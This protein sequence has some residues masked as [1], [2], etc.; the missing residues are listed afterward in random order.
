MVANSPG[1]QLEETKKLC[2]DGVSMDFWWG[3]IE[4]EKGQYDF[5][6]FHQLTDEVI[7]AGLDVTSIFSTDRCG[8]N[9]GD[10]ENIPVPKWMWKDLADKL[11][12]S[13]L[14]AV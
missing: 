8:G 4:K 10:T 5:K 2:M 1:R 14:H 3:L 6:Y 9:V 11:G 7:K 12:S 13:D